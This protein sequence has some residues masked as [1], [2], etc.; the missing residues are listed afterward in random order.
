MPLIDPQLMEMLICPSCHGKLE[1]D[2]AQARLRCTQCGLAY[3]VQDGIP[4]MLI[5]E[6]IK[7]E[8]WEEPE[9]AGSKQ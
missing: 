3:P 6:A 7:P 1:E 5:D 4:V 2:E 8:G 9:T